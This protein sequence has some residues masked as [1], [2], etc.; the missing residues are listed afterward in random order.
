VV[1]QS[2]ALQTELMVWR[3]RGQVIER[4]AY[5]VVKTP[6]DPGYYFG[7][8]L[9]LPQAPTADSVAL[10]QARFAAE[11]PSTEI[12]HITLWWDQ[13]SLDADAQRSLSHAGFTIENI[14]VMSQ[15]ST[16]NMSEASVPDVEIRP[17]TIAEAPLLATLAASLADRKDDTYVHFLQ[18]RAKWQQSLMIRGLAQFFGA[19]VSESLVAS[20]GV[21]A[22]ETLARCQDVQTAIGY[23]KR[24]LASALLSRAAAWSHQRQ[25]RRL[26]IFAEPGGAAHRLY[27]SIGFEQ[28]ATT[29]SACRYPMPPPRSE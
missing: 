11:F 7:N 25:V 10:W 20:L 26:V 9:L 23:R 29:A 3:T 17:I 18:R 15:A 12:R 21:V 19:F 22:N 5:W 6:S 28:L 4:P 16:G 24:G 1:I 27:R 14:A 8:L 13:G 2:L